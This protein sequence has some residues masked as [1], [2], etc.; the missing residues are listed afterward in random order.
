[1]LLGYTSR[2]SVRYPKKIGLVHLLFLMRARS[3]HKLYG[4]LA[5][6]PSS[7]QIFFIGTRGEPRDELYGT[8]SEVKQDGMKDVDRLQVFCYR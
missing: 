5:S 3:G 4:H 2:K 1:M 8:G 6:S 7:P